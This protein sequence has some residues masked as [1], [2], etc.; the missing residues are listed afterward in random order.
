[1]VGK[2]INAL[3]L[4]VFVYSIIKAIPGPRLDFGLVLSNSHSHSQ[5]PR[6]VFW[7]VY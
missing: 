5:N 6:N 7:T 2:K 1:L 3:E 4:P